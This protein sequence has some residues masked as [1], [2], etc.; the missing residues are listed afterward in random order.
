MSCPLGFTEPFG[1]YPRLGGCG[2]ERWE[3][4]AQHIARWTVL[5]SWVRKRESDRC[6]RV[7]HALG[8]GWHER[9]RAIA[10][11]PLLPVEGLGD[12]TL[13][14]DALE[15]WP[16]DSATHIYVRLCRACLCTSVHQPFV[17]T[18]L[19]IMRPLRCLPARRAARGRDNNPFY[20]STPARGAGTRSGS[21]A[22]ASTG[23]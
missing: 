22:S 5:R 10:Q 18:R 21:S 11:R 6:C 17:H 12:A 20:P 3:D 23:R 8:A 14:V 1:T 16:R 19:P 4:I 2:S 13:L 7:L 9:R 15:R